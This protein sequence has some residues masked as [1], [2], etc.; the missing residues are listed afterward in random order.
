MTHKD[1]LSRGPRGYDRE[2]IDFGN[3]ETERDVQDSG[4]S[5]D[6]PRE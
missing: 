3:C 2:D 5:V 4:A 1:D 6:E